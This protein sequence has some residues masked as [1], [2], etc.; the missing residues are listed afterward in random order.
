[1]KPLLPM[2]CWDAWKLSRFPAMRDGDETEERTVSTKYTYYDSGIGATGQVETV[3][4][5]IGDETDPDYVTTF[6]YCTTNG[7]PESESKTATLSDGT[8]QTITTTRSYDLP[9]GRVKKVVGGQYPVQYGY[10][11]YGEMDSLKTWQNDSVAAGFVETS[12]AYDAATGLLEAKRYDNADGSGVG[13]DYTYY[14]DGKLHT[15]AWARKT[16]DDASDPRVTTTYTYHSFGELKKTGYNDGTDPVYYGTDTTE[17][18]T[19][20][21]RMGRPTQIIDAQGTRSLTYTD[22]GALDTE[23]ISGVYGLDHKFDAL[24][25][26][27]GFELDTVSPVQD[28]TYG[29]D[30]L[31][32]F[33][34]VAY[35]IGTDS[36]TFT[37]S[38]M[39]GAD[40]LTG[41][42]SGG[43]DPS[44]EVSYAYEANRD[45]K[46]DVVNTS[47]GSEIS[48]FSYTYDEIGRRS[49]R[50]D[51][52]YSRTT[53]VDNRF[54]YNE[55][56]EVVGADMDGNAAAFEDVYTYDDI[57]N[58]INSTLDGGTQVNYTR[59]N[60][61]QYSALSGGTTSS[62]SYDEDG[63]LESDGTWTY[64]WNAENRLVAM[65]K[66]DPEEGDER[67]EFLYDFMGR[68]YGKDMYE[69]SSGSFSATP[70]EET[71]FVY[72]G[73]NLVHEV[74]SGSVVVTRSY[75][76]GLDLSQTLQGAGGVGGLLM[77]RSNFGPTLYN[78]PLA[79]ANGNITDYVH[80]TGTA[81]AHFEYDA[82]GNITTGTGAWK[83]LFNFRFSSKYQDLSSELYYYGF[84]Y[85]SVDTGRWINRDPKEE[86]GGLNLYGFVQNRAISHVDAL[87][88]K[89]FPV[90]IPS[91]YW[92]NVVV[93]VEV[94]AQSCDQGGGVEI[95]NILY[96]SG[97]EPT[98]GLDAF[99]AVQLLAVGVW[100][101]SVIQFYQFENLTPTRQEI[102]D[103][104]KVTTGCQ[105]GYSKV[106]RKFKIT[107]GYA[108]K[109][110]N[111]LPFLGDTIKPM[112][113]QN[114]TGGVIVK[115]M[116]PCCCDD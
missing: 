23:A 42:N 49:Q 43:E 113:T 31:G 67:L 8:S 84:R 103:S 3:T 61:N 27:A 12:W 99:D 100:K 110:F 106:M 33:E 24:G 115:I 82:F 28:I 16:G 20:L 9:T 108:I 95:G 77:Q 92:A 5:V 66:I 30:A 114:Q 26:P 10:N 15:R 39:D 87:G 85:Y 19:L 64:E 56:S 65:E 75:I 2:I 73:W 94:I 109:Q 18:T 25:R 97:H 71:I 96:A 22:S 55:R 34:T 37:Y 11:D 6:T 1:M 45:L 13:P 51:S 93:N 36:D 86:D 40:L 102:G 80:T 47:C 35:T 112:R 59:N 50:E 91:Q 4:Q 52:L 116:G 88:L 104:T 111:W 17:A 83:D 46:T 57:G 98:S 74:G 14:A 58:R 68:R 72:D 107:V 60:L 63:N 89:I 44:V 81:A 69:Y 7:L 48:S 53:P 54:L 90:S 21:D 38:W 70:D 79:D 76:W 62:L 41:Y 78:Y 29:Y 101:I 32:R 105:S